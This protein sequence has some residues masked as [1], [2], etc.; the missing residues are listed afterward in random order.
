[1]PDERACALSFAGEMLRELQRIPDV[2]E[3]IRHEARV[4]LRHYPTAHDLKSMIEAVD[5]L[6]SPWALFLDSVARLR[7]TCWCAGP[8]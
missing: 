6:T 5:R 7:Y 3:S 1:M 4:T 8:E 2:P